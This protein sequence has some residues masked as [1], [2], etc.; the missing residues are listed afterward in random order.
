MVMGAQ[1]SGAIIA[2]AVVKYLIPNGREVK[3]TLSLSTNTSITRGLLLEMFFT[4]ELIFTILMLAAEVSL[5]TA[6]WSIV[7][8]T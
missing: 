5:W 2:A 7:M 3:H 8:N 6:I 1:I 4:A